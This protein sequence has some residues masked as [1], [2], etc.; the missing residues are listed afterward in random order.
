MDAQ[1]FRAALQRLPAGTFRLI[2][3]EQHRAPRIGQPVRQM[4]QDASAGDHAARRN[5]DAGRD[6]IVDLL[7]ILDGARHMDIVDV[8][9]I[10]GW[11][12]CFK[13]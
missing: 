1:E 8:Q 3:H 6:H 12:A 9:R 5:N 7:R 4:M 2:A 13:S 10:R 11:S